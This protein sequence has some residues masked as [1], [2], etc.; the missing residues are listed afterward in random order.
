MRYF[1]V[2]FSKSYFNYLCVYV[3]F[4]KLT[5][6]TQ[7]YRFLYEIFSNRNLRILQFFKYFIGYDLI[8]IESILRHVL[9]LRR[10]QTARLFRFQDVTHLRLTGDGNCFKRLASN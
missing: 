2:N 9:Y 1:F 5:L 6:Y 10:T 3:L 4:I 8:L 7:L